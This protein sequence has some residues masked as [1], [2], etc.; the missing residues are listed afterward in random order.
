MLRATEVQGPT[1]WR[2]LLLDGE[3]AA[4]D[5]E[6]DLDPTS[7]EYEALADLAGYLRRNAAPDDRVPSEAGIVD[8]LGAWL[9]ERLLGPRIGRL[10]VDGDADVVRVELGDGA[11]LLPHWPLELSHVDGVPL[12]RHGIGLVYQWSAAP[13]R[14]KQP[15]GERLRILALFSMPSATS[16]LALRRE[17]YELTRL[18]GA[19]AARRAVELRV[20]Q[21]GVTRERLRA[22]A[23]EDPGWDVLHLAG[24]GLA[25]GLLLEHD[26]GSPDEVSTADLVSLLR[27][28]RSRLKLAVLGSCDSGAAT[29][30]E[31][32]RRLRLDEQA[33]ELEAADGPD[34]D[35]VGLARGVV[36]RLGVAAVAMRYPVS[37]DFAIALTAELY[38][39]LLA[40]MPVDRAVALAVP[41]AAGE[42][43]SAARPPLSLG[44]PA[45]F[46][47]ASG[48]AVR[49]PEGAVNLDPN[50]PRMPATFKE[51]ERFVGRT[52]LLI[53]AA[54]ALA[55]RSGRAG[56]LLV[57]MAGAGK[58][59]A[60]QELAH[61]HGRFDAL[62]YRHGRFG[63]L[64]WWQAPSGE[65]G[66]GEAIVGLAH[67]LEIQ[68]GHL[69]FTMVDDLSSED[70]LRGFLHR[71]SGL[72]RDEAVLL[73]LDNLET[74]LSR[75]GAW[76][77]PLWAA[78]V[79]ALTGHGGLSRVVLTSR[80]V[81]QGLDTD[82]VEVLPTHALSLAES[83]L[84]ARE[85]PNLRAML[86][87]DSG[88]ERDAGVA[89]DRQLARAV[90]HVVQGH[91]KLLELADAAASNPD[92]LRARLAAAE[93]TAGDA[94]LAAFFATGT[95]D[96]DGDRFLDV[97][98]R[99][100]VDALTDLPGPARRLAELLACLE[101]GDRRSE[102]VVAAWPHLWD[103]DV[104]PLD[105]AVAVLRAGAIADT[106]PVRQADPA[107]AVLYAVHPGVVEAIRG[108]LDPERRADVDELMCRIWH[109]TARRH[110]E[111]EDRGAPAAT[112][113]VVH[114]A[115]AA[116]PYLLRR[117]YFAEAAALL[118][119]VHIRDRAPGTVARVLGHLRQ[120]NA[121]ET[122]EVRRLDGELLYAA[123]SATVV[124]DEA[125]AL[126]RDLLDRARARGL[127]QLAKAT[128][129]QLAEVLQARGR[130]AEAFLIADE[131]DNELARLRILATTG[132][133]EEV[134]AQAAALLENLD[135][136][137]VRW[138]VLE[139]VLD[140]A[141]FAAR[142]VQD[143]SLALEFN[144]RIQHSERRRGASAHEQAKT[145]FN[146]SNLLRRLERHAEAD[147][148]LDECR[149][150]FEDLG[151]V[152][153]LGEVF[154]S[155][156]RAEQERGRLRL[157][158]EFEER[159]M[160]YV[161][162]RPE[163]NRV[164][165]C[166]HNLG[167]YLAQAGR[168]ADEPAAAAH[169]LAAT[170]LWH[171]TGHDAF[172][173]AMHAL[174]RVVPRPAGDVL[175]AGV[176]ELADRVGSVPG[177]RFGQVLA[178]VLP[179]EGRRDAEF[180]AVADTAERFFYG[181]DPDVFTHRTPPRPNRAQRRKRRKR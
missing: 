98:T 134:L 38:P 53:D 113:Q 118:G 149:Q 152:V 66:P 8:R 130:L 120:A 20:L 54:R 28:A 19:V 26:D 165:I 140:V 135:E 133:H 160:R 139:Q 116:V 111:R 167:Q 73:V 29:A 59:T 122:D 40:G 5:H 97:L 69:G 35:T 150:V 76:R 146:E 78:L 104:P 103:A 169:L 1:R 153:Q 65:A 172:H 77:D 7:A 32:M 30:A 14:V 99:W 107:S 138:L 156:A 95:S 75:S 96:L 39:R 58:T 34:A 88:P 112:T 45:L 92:R 123:V 43:P 119:E 136:D 168:K 90:I 151:D 129:E 15:V 87:Q 154:S 56:V 106:V 50:R 145:R 143:W 102:V 74:L 137:D 16:V 21:Y 44:T 12:A 115:L 11:H 162:Q 2:W 144:R 86:H 171:V 27:P 36:D 79:E 166:H 62:S 161:Y 126:L 70:G 61:Q 24:H 179:D 10:I 141:C 127:E 31:T 170:L 155:R 41:A 105:A 83:I 89:A 4:A 60:A 33:D 121:G 114:A 68:L 125:E 82:A 142:G 108:G 101:D 100:T 25:G 46:G 9:G 52:R 178:D 13:A 164:A 23:E 3:H 71:L 22:T 109:E 131:F 93:R 80:V 110:L 157:A 55:P 124:P 18:I 132:R 176:E 51:P 163:A 47:P 158:I 117:S 174:S 128:A 81:P 72:L 94:P 91:P 17:R 42:H 49:P 175:P 6:V 159:A 84:L 63:A 180:R 67:A 85:L 64:A 148:V 181:V 37:D 173:S 147:R 48:L 177:V 57:G